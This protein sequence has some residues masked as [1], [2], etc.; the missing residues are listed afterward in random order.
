MFV[1]AGRLPEAL[2]VLAEGG[3]VLIIDITGAENPV[4]YSGGAANSW[5]TWTDFPV[6]QE[7]PK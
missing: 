2:C 1:L 3:E 6:Y 4:N 5:D 7:N